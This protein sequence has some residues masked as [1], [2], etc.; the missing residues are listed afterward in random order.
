MKV[1]FV[2]LK[3]QYQAI[4]PGID[5]AIGSVVQDAAF[6][7]GKYVEAF[8]KQFAEMC[9]CRHAVGVSSGTSAL[10]LAMVA[11]GIGPG[12]EVV[13]V[14]NTFLAT[15]EAVTHAGAKFRLVD[16]KEQ[17][18]NI[19]VGAIAKAMTPKTKAIIPVHL[20]GQ[21]AEMDAI[22][23][24]AAR[25]GLMVIEDACQAQGAE[26]KGKRAGA[27]GHA[28]G[29]SFY[30]AK[31]LGAY[32]DAGAVTTDDEVVAER[33]RLYANHGRRSSNDH[34]VEGFNARLDG[35]QA[36]VLSAKLPHLEGWNR[37]RSEAA[38]RYDRLLAGLD[39]EV[40]KQTPGA[41]HIYHLYVIRV[42]NRD[43]VKAEMESRGV[44]C[45]LHYPIPLHLLDA[46]KYLGLGPGSFPATEA[47]AREI[48]SLPM[49]AEITEE[50][51]RYVAD[52]LRDAVG[53]A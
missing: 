11:M 46:Y 13:T 25:R 45:G 23:D 5:S 32:G 31:N 3:S 14:A 24:L 28:A 38:A 34:A 41:K 22:M 4:K 6:V 51:Q 9:G 40:P 30:P 29:F 15:T 44:G 52:C 33:V 27:W 48:L 20:Y 2:D 37:M 10:H 12:D 7:G 43:R 35:I 49:F 1:P 36:A 8:E 47:A 50:Q 18:F 16:I 19:D 53:K 21:M 17:T 39:V 26:Y 42:K